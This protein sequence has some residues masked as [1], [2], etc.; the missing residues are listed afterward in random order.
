MQ[1]WYQI[2]ESDDEDVPSFW[3]VA[4]SLPLLVNVEP[5]LLFDGKSQAP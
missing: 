1:T 3:D 4:L 2:M 5:L